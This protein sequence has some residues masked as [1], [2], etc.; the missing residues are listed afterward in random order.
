MVINSIRTS[1]N[2]PA[3]ELME[4]ADEM[5]LIILSVGFDMWELSKT[6]YD[7]ACFFTEWHER[8]VA[9]LVRRDRNHPSLMGWSIGNEICDTHV[10]EPGVITVCLTSPSLSMN[11]IH[12]M[13]SGSD[14]EKRLS[15]SFRVSNAIPNADLRVMGFRADSG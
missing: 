10:S 11:S 3:V 4:L 8:D 9:A 1:H 15:A 5:G 2:P 13:F 12:A 7:Y 14:G 6:E